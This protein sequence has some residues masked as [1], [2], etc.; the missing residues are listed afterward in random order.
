MKK[1]I[2]KADKPSKAKK[3]VLQ[4][5]DHRKIDDELS[6]RI[7]QQAAVAKLGQDALLGNELS[8]LFDEAVGVIAKTLDVEYCKVLELLSEGDVLLLRSGVG[9]KDGLV[10]Y[11]TVGAQANSQAGYTLLSSEPVI[12]EDLRTETRF[13]G[14]ALLHEHGVVS[15]MSVIIHGKGRPFDVLGIHT[16]HLRFFTKDDI[17]FLQ[18]VA[19]VLANAIE[20]KGT[21]E[22][23]ARRKAEFEAMFNFIP[24]A[25]MFA[26]INRRIVMCNPAVQSILGYTH[27]ELQGKTTEIL[28][29]EKSDYEEQGRLRYNVG[30]A[31]HGKPYEMRYRRKDGTLLA[32]E[33]HSS[34]V[35]DSSGRTL[36]FVAIF[37]D[38]A[39][40]KR[41]EEHLLRTCKL[42][43][44]GVL[45]GGI[46]HDFNNILTAI[47]AN[48][49]LSKTYVNPEDFI[50]Q[51]LS[52]AEKASIR[53]RDLT[54]RLLIF[55]K[56][57]A[58]VKRVASI[59]ELVRESADFALRGS[60]IG[61]DFSIPDDLWP[62][63]VD[64]GQISQVIHNIMLNAV[65]AVTDGGAVYVHCENAAVG[66]NEAENNPSLQKGDYVKI[67]IKD[68]GIGIPA[69][70]LKK[71]FD[72]YFTTKPKGSGLGLATTYSIVKNH[73]GLITV[74][75]RT[76]VGTVFNIYLPASDKK[77][78]A[79]QKKENIPF[80]GKGRVLVMDD[81][82]IVRDAAGS[83]LK[84]IG[85][86]AEA[87]K[88]G[89]EA[90]EIYRKG[91]ESGRPF[92]AVIMDLTIPGGMG[93]KEAIKRLLEIDPDAK[94]IVSSGYS[95]DP[96][97]AE[98]RKY[99]FCGVI[100]KPYETEQL[101]RALSDVINGIK[102]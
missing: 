95:E 54:Q 90:I 81:E 35:K 89:A 43:S 82:D 7:Q 67:S 85:Y 31:G 100:A 15:G 62:A 23:L 26:D 97:M 40:R 88:D 8:K 29:A 66:R 72:P 3:P 98:F 36:G 12:V 60:D 14:P 49:S 30:S 83:V 18:A 21:E 59:T 76:G 92:D 32:A 6:A 77:I 24:D 84:C 101:S 37:R 25:V 74:E 13:N 53:A 86:E 38:L 102:G 45:A 41:M 55:A 70:N 57:G 75:S 99:G 69:E 52:E 50:Y 4:K 5:A 46:A 16:T 34:P 94:A 22:S 17:H 33:T 51:R 80:F 73:N 63:E 28:Y 64:E 58:P 48:I 96:V 2:K 47:L 44:L 71:I 9:W 39:E 1:R 11:A 68:N 61:C 20:R 78:S 87:A 91:M 27:A 42:E 10:G 56:G 79:K 93:G 19:N 65:Q